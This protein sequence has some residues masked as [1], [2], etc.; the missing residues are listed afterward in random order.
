MDFTHVPDNH[1]AVQQWFERVRKEIYTECGSWERYKDNSAALDKLI[2]DFFSGKFSTET[3]NEVSTI[4][5]DYQ[6]QAADVA[7]I[8][9]LRDGLMLPKA[10]ENM[11][12]TEI[13]E[14]NIWK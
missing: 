14:D 6:T 3:I 10:L 8:L 1:K 4:I 12:I 7:Y 13:L 5:C 11:T 9:G 2:E